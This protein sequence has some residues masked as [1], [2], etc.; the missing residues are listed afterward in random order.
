MDVAKPD[1]ASIAR[2]LKRISSA[3][4]KVCVVGSAN[5]DLTVIVDQLPQPGQTISGGPLSELPG[6]KS[7]NQAVTAGLLGATVEFVGAVGQDTNGDMLLESLGDGGVDTDFVTRVE[8]PTGTA[9]IVVDSAAE[10]FIVLSPGANGDVDADMVRRNAAAFDGAGVLGLCLEVDDAVV[11]EAARIAQDN[12]IPVVFNLSPIRD[13]SDEFLSHVDVLIVNEH[14]L[15]AVVGED[16]ATA[17]V[18]HGEWSQAAQA[19]RG[20]HGIANAVVTVGSQG[21]VVLSDDGETIVP[22]VP[23]TVKDTTGCGDSYMG[24]LLAC[25]AVDM[26]VTDAAQLA[27]VVSAYAA[28]GTGA[29]R[30]YG[31]AEDIQRFVESLGKEN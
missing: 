11:L 13:V 4:K 20:D 30:S 19:L 15:A 16:V 2:A 5:A 6:G 18:D 8:T 10:N 3:D 17:A 12:G 27:A 23:I 7:A 25:L 21:S 28:T 1:S 29:Q 22:P 9:M 24:T 31:N 26:Q 14:E